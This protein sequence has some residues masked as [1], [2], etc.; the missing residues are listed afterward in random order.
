M[1]GNKASALLVGKQSLPSLLITPSVVQQS[2]SSHSIGQHQGSVTPNRSPSSQHINNR[3]QFQSAVGRSVQSPRVS[4][5]VVRQ[6]VYLLVFLYKKNLILLLRHYWNHSISALL[7]D[8]TKNLQKIIPYLLSSTT[9]P[10]IGGLSGLGG[11][12]PIATAT[13]RHTIPK[14]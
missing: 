8:T 4:Q 7:L 11:A 9:A 2:A 1:R 14:L 3:P 5:P 10:S 6:V 12:R 13:A